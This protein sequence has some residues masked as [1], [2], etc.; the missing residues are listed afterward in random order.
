MS[1]IFPFL[2]IFLFLYTVSFI[3][4]LIR[5]RLTKLQAGFVMMI[6]GAVLLLLPVAQRL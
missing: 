6:L 5:G 1:L 4:A 2:A 3:V